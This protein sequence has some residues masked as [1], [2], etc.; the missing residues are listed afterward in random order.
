MSHS[1][2]KDERSSVVIGT[3]NSHKFVE[4][5]STL[6]VLPFEY[7]PLSN[8]SH[9][10]PSETGTTFVENALIKA[11]YA[12]KCADL[13][14]IADDSGLIVD[15]LDGAPGIHSSR[16]AGDHASDEENNNLLLERI[17]SK[18]QS[19]KV[20]N[21]CFV[22]IL[23]YLEHADDSKPVIAEGR[24]PGTIID[25]P[26][27]ELGFGYDPLFLPLDSSQTAAELG[28]SIKNRDSHRANAA[29]KLVRSLTDRKVVRAETTSRIN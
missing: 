21:A 14:A 27:G 15:L 17:K 10:P 11:R 6:R 2:I 24:W 13:P 25:L 22:A 16:Y 3:H 4:L 8:W 12:C 18:R 1:D 7:L 5:T 29:R 28:P 23:V 9:K 26:R 20:V 19:N